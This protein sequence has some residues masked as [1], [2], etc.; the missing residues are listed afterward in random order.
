MYERVR[1]TVTDRQT[2]EQASI[3]NGSSLPISNACLAL[4]AEDDDRGGN[5]LAFSFSQ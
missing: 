1:P 2:I 3:P 4:I 5:R